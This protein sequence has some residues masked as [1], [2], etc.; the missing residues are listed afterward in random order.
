MKNILKKKNLDKLL[1]ISLIIYML[2]GT[3]YM[4]IFNH[5]E[6]SAPNTSVKYS[7]IPFILLWSY[8]ILTNKLMRKQFKNK[9]SLVFSI[10]VVGILFAIL[11]TGYVSFF[12]AALPHI[13]NRTTIEGRILEIYESYSVKR[14][15]SYI[16]ELDK[17]NYFGENSN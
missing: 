5:T 12:N 3:F 9:F 4:I 10:V 7:I 8:F 17:K 11:S 13:K 6:I 14:G 1:F 15:T 16:I 2:I